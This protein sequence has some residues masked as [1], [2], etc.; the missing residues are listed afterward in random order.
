MSEDKTKY[1]RVHD[2]VLLVLE[3]L[4]GEVRDSSGL[5]V[6]K[7]FERMATTSTYTDVSSIMKDLEEEGLIIRDQPSLKRTT[8]VALA[9]RGF[10]PPVKDVKV[11]LEQFSRSLAEDLEGTVN[12]LVDAHVQT[13]LAKREDEVSAQMNAELEKRNK[14]LQE[15]VGELREKV[16]RAQ[17]KPASLQA[18]N[19]QLEQEVADLRERL[20]IA[21]HNAEVWKQNAMG[22]PRFREA[23]AAFKD[24]LPPEQKRQLERMMREVPSG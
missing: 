22:K 19:D 20:R 21:E 15:Q 4:G 17:E 14:Q 10:A 3:E 24:K 9:D 23:M 13:E 6:R 2:E 11:V 7:I 5:A 1:E 18:K 12:R 16:K 8:R